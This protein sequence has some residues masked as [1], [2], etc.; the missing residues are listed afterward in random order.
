MS[1]NNTVKATLK[2][3]RI[4]PRKMALVA[5]LVRGRSV[6]DAIIILQHTP[7]RGAL[8][9]KKLIESA[10][11]NATNN[12]GLKAEGLR[13]TKLSVVAGARLKR[14]KPV[15]RG[16]AH[17]FQ[18]RTSHIYVEVSGDVKPVKKPVEKKAEVK[19]EEA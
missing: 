17:P 15:S 16:M 8:P 2:E 10:K 1:V 19:K 12:H 11:A 18:K 3:L 5:A 13:I 9:L 6:E 4:A 14:Y 7:K